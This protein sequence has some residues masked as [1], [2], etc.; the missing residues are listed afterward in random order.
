MKKSINKKLVC[1]FIFLPVIG[2]LFLNISAII[3]SRRG[4]SL[5]LPISGYDPRDL[6]SGHYL[7][8]D[9]DYGLNTKCT[10][11]GFTEGKHINEPRRL[12]RNNYIYLCLDEGKKNTF[13][14]YPNKCKLKIR[15]KCKKS[16]FVA[17]IERFYIPENKAKEHEKLLLDSSNK[18]ELEVLIRNDGKTNVKDLLINGVPIK[19]H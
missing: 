4:T 11:S 15:G 12:I 9:I 3:D 1:F 6:L 18:A 19:N 17:G 2:I 10:Y 13:N 16:R 8:Y 14:K 7:R 5:Y